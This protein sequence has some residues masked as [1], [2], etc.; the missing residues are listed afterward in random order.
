[1]CRALRWCCAGALCCATLSFAHQAPN[2]K[3]ANEPIEAEVLFTDNSVVRMFLLQ[4]QIEILTKYGKLTVPITDV[5][6]IDFGVHVAPETEKKVAQ[7]I[8]DLGSENY[9]TRDLALK[10][11]IGLGP[12]AYPQVHHALHSGQLEVVK[13]AVTAMEKIKAK[14]PARSLRLREEDIIT[15]SAF[16]MVGR[17]STQFL[18]AKNENFGELDLKVP[19]LRQLRLLNSSLETEF[20]VDAARHGSGVGQWLDTGI[21]IH[22]GLRLQITANGSVNLWPQGPGYVCTPRG[23][24]VNGP[25]VAVGGQASAAFPAG[26]LVGRIGED[27]APFLIGET[28][29]GSPNRDGRLF[30]HI[31]P[32]PWNNASTGNYLVK[33]AP[34]AESGNGD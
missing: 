32:S 28:Y 20:N 13:R 22:T 9:R 5:V 10:Q 29:T 33:V 27:G 1:M 26:A 31:V 11:L 23:Y 14:F 17:I 6:K 12:E 30:L 19:K 18:R 15:T 34:L 25:Q 3:K 4:N 21:E 2:V 16:T 24:N 8:E 7:A